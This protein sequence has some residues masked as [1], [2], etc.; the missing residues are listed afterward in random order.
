[1]CSNSE[2]YSAEKVRYDKV[3]CLILWLSDFKCGLCEFFWTGA[4]GAASCGEMQYCFQRTGR[5]AHLRKDALCVC[6][7]RNQRTEKV[8]KRDSL[9]STRDTKR[10]SNLCL[11]CIDCSVHVLCGYW[12]N[13]QIYIFINNILICAQRCSSEIPNIFRK[14]RF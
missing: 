14:Y 11:R 8:I 4:V 6:V 1:M 10:C 7:L 12:I 3:F 9:D 13:V 5:T 2:L